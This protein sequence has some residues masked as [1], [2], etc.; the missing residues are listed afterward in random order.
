M[1][2][3]EERLLYDEKM[4]RISELLEELVLDAMLHAL[5][6]IWDSN[7]AFDET[8]NRHKK[9]DDMSF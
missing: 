5:Q 8:S 2:R 6:C 1:N 9:T 4:E 3:M 7:T